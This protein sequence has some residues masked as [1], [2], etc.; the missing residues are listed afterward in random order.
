MFFQK[1]K[2]YIKNLKFSWSLI[3][4]ININK[5][6]TLTK[7]IIDSLRSPLNANNIHGMHGTRKVIL[8]LVLKQ[9]E[10]SNKS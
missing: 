6:Y 8:R 2:K 3:R 10:E 1:Y 7:K 5:I 4:R 9:S